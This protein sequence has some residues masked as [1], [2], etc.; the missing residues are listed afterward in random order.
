ML[1]GDDL[2]R[3]PFLRALSIRAISFAGCKSRLL[4]F[5]LFLVRLF[6]LI[7]AVD[8]MH[9]AT[10]KLLPGT[11]ATMFDRFLGWLGGDQTIAAVSN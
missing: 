11:L 6:L 2:T 7:R 3:I 5:A 10:A 4:A 8:L 9:V 1:A